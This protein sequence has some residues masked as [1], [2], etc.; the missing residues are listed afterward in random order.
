MK[1]D[2][3]LDK[4]DWHPSPLAGQ[5]VLVSSHDQDGNA[6]VA[7]KSWVT[8]VAFAGPIVAFGC[9]VGHATYRNVLAT[10][11]FVINIAPTTLADRVW[12]LSD[13]HGEER[14]RDSG[15]TLEPAAAVAAPRV[16]ECTAHLEC[17]LDEIKEWG[18]EVLIFGRVVAV[19][20]EDSYGALD[21]MFFLENGT[22]A[23]LGEPRRVT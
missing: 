22:Y 19:R 9:N 11:E 2:V 12:A 13:L 5:I 17:V 20:T 16:A 23:P 6:N 7:P 4:H 8:M 3:P 14:R 15:L 10:R 1:R 18:D 21:P